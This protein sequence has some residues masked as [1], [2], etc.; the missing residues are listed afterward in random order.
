V[1]EELKDVGPMAYDLAMPVTK[2]DI[3]AALARWSK[4]FKWW[5]RKT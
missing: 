2:A 4:V 3:P 5:M 1:S